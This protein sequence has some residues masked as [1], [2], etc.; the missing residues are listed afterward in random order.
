MT[1]IITSIIMLA[2]N[3]SLTIL[4]YIVVLALV[5]VSWLITKSSGPA[6]VL[7]QDKTG[8]LNGFAEEWISGAK[9]VISCRRQR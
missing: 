5:G 1:I 9:T 4:S 8:D 6:F 2:I 7:L 3:P